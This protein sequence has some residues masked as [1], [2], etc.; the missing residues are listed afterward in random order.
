MRGFAALVASAVALLIGMVALSTSASQVTTNTTAGNET[1]ELLEGVST[2]W[3]TVLAD[4]LPYLAVVSLT[5][6]GMGVLV[7][8]S[9]GR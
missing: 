6:L 9:R 1:A 8:A 7:L 3:A 2:G 4:G 5:V